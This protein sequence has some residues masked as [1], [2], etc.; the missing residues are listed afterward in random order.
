M[1]NF[2]PDDFI[3]EKYPTP[4]E[5][6]TILEYDAKAK[7]ILVRVNNFGVYEHEASVLSE[8]VNNNLL[9]HIPD[10]W[11]N[12]NDKLALF[13]IRED[14]TFGLEKEKL[15]YD[16]K[17]K[18]TKWVRYKCKNFTLEQAKELFEIIKAAIWVQNTKTE[19]ELN[20]ELLEL[21]K[22]KAYLDKIH[23]RKLDLLNRY[24]R[25]T[26]WRILPD[27]PQFF[28]GEQELWI[29]WRDRMRECVKSPD[30]F[31]SEI[32][33]LM[34]CEEFKWPIN[35]EMYYNLYP[36]REVEY[37]S[38]EDQF[39]TSD[40]TV[41]NETMKVISARVSQYISN[42]Q[43]REENGVPVERR[44]YDLIRKYSLLDNIDNIKLS[45]EGE[46]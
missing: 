30:D 21:S 43:D 34:Y 18:E 11:S 33:Y 4:E 7:L 35:P 10:E 2:N 40:P 46:S 25:S 27:A 6:P 29:I 3:F 16:V 5:N 13:W 44:M 36:D 8:I 23:L 39:T 15:K 1:T 42:L 26:D 14:G 12:R 37:L 45:V 32:D 22:K 28:E 20:R 38:T 9:N 19:E 41:T 17:T 24:L 31:D